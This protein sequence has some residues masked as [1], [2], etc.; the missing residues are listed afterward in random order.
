MTK[1]SPSRA[2]FSIA[3]LAVVLAATALSSTMGCEAKVHC[4][5]RI[6]EDKVGDETRTIFVIVN[7][8]ADDI[9]DAQL[10]VDG[11]PLEGKEGTAGA[12]TAT[13]REV[14]SGKETKIGTSLLEGPE[15]AKFTGDMKPTKA[16]LKVGG[17]VAC[18][19]AGK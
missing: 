16:T 1:R 3:T 5:V 18:E 14:L 19:V 12:Y 7:R 17:K 6:A 11:V 4:D 13:V 8:S 9:K 10:I 15:K 2:S